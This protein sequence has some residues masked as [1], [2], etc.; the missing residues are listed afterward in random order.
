[1]FILNMKASVFETSKQDVVIRD[2]NLFFSYTQRE[3]N[4]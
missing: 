1:M 2:R 4:F 3:N